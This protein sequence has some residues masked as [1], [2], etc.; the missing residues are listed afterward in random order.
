[1]T[2]VCAII[3][4]ICFIIILLPNT[5]ARNKVLKQLHWSHWHFCKSYNTK[6]ANKNDNFSVYKSYV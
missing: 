2:S 3:K 6:K 1:M 4:P 5:S